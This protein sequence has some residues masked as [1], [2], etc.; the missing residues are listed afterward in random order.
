M[1]HTFALT[2]FLVVCTLV[3]AQEKTISKSFSDVKSIRLNTASG[4]IFLKKS[5]DASVRLLLKHTYNDSEFTPFIEQSSTRLTLKE[6]FSGGSHSGNSSWTL[7]IP[8][9][10]RIDIN[11]GSGDITVDNLA[12]DMKSNS[13]SGDIM[14]TGVK[15]DMNFN[16]G[17]G[18]YELEQTGGEVSLNTGSG[19]VRA[20]GGTGNYRFNSGSGSI[21]LDQLKGD[22]D[23]NSG[24]GNIQAKAIVVNTSSNVNSGSGDA[25]ITL[26]AP[27]TSN[28]SVNSGSGDATLNFANNAISGQV[29]MTA[30]ERSGNIVAP[31]AFDKEETLTQGD[32]NQARIQKTAKLGS[33]NILI[34][35]ST[36]SGTA[37]IAK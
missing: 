37:E 3:L 11:T 36:G 26:G 34:K 2:L 10:T 13:G 4:N 20:T 1:K 22:F 23:M 33:G 35:V 32:R 24:S 6:E 17:S 19:D 25:T 9:N 27:L 28:I 14:L 18:D 8:D 12:I 29:V 16:T 21:R 30:N 15:G 31:F 7:E 5:A